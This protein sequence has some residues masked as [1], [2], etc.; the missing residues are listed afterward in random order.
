MYSSRYFGPCLGCFVSLTILTPLQS[1]WAQFPGVPIDP[2]AIVQR[3]EDAIR[4]SSQSSD[5]PSMAMI[6]R[7]RAKSMSYDNEIKHVQTYFEKRKLNREYRAA[8]GRPQR[9][10]E[11]IVA[12]RKARQPD[13]LTIAEYDAYRGRV[14]WPVL[15]RH[16]HFQS[17][18]TQLDGLL[19]QHASAGGGLNTMQYAS[20]AKAIDSMSSELDR[21]HSRLDPNQYVYTQRFLKSLRYEASFAVGS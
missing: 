9:T 21:Y 4:D 18:R 10:T 12:A 1:S 14:N 3:L 11:Q 13:R 15:I 5:R 6:D 2:M 17:V 16:Q 20:I 7:E 19:V 8:E